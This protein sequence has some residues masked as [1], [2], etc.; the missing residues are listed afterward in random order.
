MTFFL[1][2]M[3][4]RNYNS[5][6][7]FTLIEALIALL[8]F[9]LAILAVLSFAPRAIRLALH[10][11]LQTQAIFLSQAKQEE[12][13]AK[14]YLDLDVGT[15]EAR[16][17]F[18]TDTTSQLHIFET[19]VIVASIDETFAEVSE[20]TGMKK[21]TVNTY[22]AEGNREYQETLVTFVSCY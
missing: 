22:W 12:Y 2:K 18:T 8:V 3:V 10:A 4:T 9:T 20:E 17:V 16:A 14:A 15:I 7:G 21:I 19:E 13:L 5:N 11:R 6:K 1:Y